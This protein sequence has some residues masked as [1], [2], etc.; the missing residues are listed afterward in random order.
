M[1][2]L[3]S[4]VEAAERLGVAPQR[5][6]AL[7]AAGRLPA[8]RVGNRHVLDAEVVKSFGRRER[9]PGR[10]LAAGSAWALLGE[11]SGCPDVA[12][13]SRRTAY[14]L[15]DLLAAGGDALVGALLR[16]EARSELH[17]WRVLPADIAALR[18]DSRIVASG[19]S[20]DDPSIDLRYQPQIDGLDGYVSGADLQ[21]LE[22]ELLPEKSSQAPNLLLRVPRDE[23]VWILAVSSAPAPVVAAD[24]LDHDDER[25][26]RSARA[27][28]A[29]AAPR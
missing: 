23:G 20:A 5:V 18:G 24:L 1:D 12:A 9:V 3:L 7:I 26:R 10:P 19:M 4:S 15:R 13:P 22:R 21:A 16:S 17:P 11:L 2:R 28:L 27:A 6:R 25:V 29:G 14:R 8:V